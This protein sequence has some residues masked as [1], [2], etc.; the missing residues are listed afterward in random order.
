[1]GDNLP[2]TQLLNRLRIL[3]L[4]KLYNDIKRVLIYGSPDKFNG[5]STNTNFWEYKLYGNHTSVTQHV[6]NT[7]AIINKE[8]R[9]KFLLAFP[10]WLVRFI[11][12]LHITPIAIVIIPGK[13]DRLIFHASF[14]MHKQSIYVNQWTHKSNEPP[15]VF[16]KALT[17]HLR[18]IYNLRIT[19]FH[20]EIYLWDDDISSAF[21]WVK[22]N[23]DI[24]TA[25]AFTVGNYLFCSTGQTFGRNI[26]PSNW[27]VLA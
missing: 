19:Y 16:S 10:N 8:E 11:P 1:M 2:R 9:N 21:R 15:L 6:E 25:F 7:L 4:R 20:Q 12:H 26:S 13:K 18:R 23:P 17:N 14:Q 24:V 27:E 3:I 5:Y 22:L